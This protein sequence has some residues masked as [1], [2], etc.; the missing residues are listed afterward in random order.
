MYSDVGLEREYMWSL[1][2]DILII[3]CSEIRCYCLD[4]SSFFFCIMYIYD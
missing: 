3:C 1:L 4:G 2:N